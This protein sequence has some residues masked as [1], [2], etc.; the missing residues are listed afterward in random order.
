MTELR[1]RVKKDH[2]LGLRI[3]LCISNELEAK[4]LPV[5]MAPGLVSSSP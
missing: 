1:Y 4:G 3:K 2:V 5:W